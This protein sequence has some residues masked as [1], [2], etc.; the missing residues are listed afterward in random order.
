MNIPLNEVRGIGL[1][2]DL[3]DPK[4]S[5]KKGTIGFLMAK[6]QKFTQVVGSKNLNMFFEKKNTAAGTN[7]QTA[8]NNHTTTDNTV[9]NNSANGLSNA[10]KSTPVNSQ[11]SNTTDT[12]K[13][14]L[15]NNPTTRNNAKRKG[16]VL[17]PSAKK[18][19]A[20]QGGLYQFFNKTKE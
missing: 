20:Q 12:T 1:S 9:N 8:T 13:T 14:N 2:V 4:E 7:T 10:V 11:K 3:A 5:A 16:D 18:P 17:A 6:R 15:N 19:N